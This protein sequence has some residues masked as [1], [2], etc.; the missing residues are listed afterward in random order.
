MSD[1]TRAKIA[2]LLMR[3]SR[4][5]C[6]VEPRGEIDWDTCADC[7]VNIAEDGHRPD[8]PG[9]TGLRVVTLREIYPHGP[10]TCEGCGEVL[11]PGDTY[12]TIPTEPITGI[13]AG[14]V[15]CVGCAATAAV[16]EDK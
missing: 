12:T 2:D 4:R 16:K 14:V 1:R 15:S 11:W 10:A 5:L 3:W 7:G 6:R 13:P 8:C 9:E